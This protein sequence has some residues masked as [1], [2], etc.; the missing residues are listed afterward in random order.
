MTLTSFR[1]RGIEFAAAGPVTVLEL[2]RVN[3]EDTWNIEVEA[4]FYYEIFDHNN[5]TGGISR[6]QFEKL[7]P[8]ILVNAA[9]S[10]MVTD[11]GTENSLVEHVGMLCDTVFQG[12]DEEVKEIISFDEFKVVTHSLTHLLTHSLTHS[13]AQ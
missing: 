7:I 4:R 6:A 13:L 9:D 10:N 2:N 1:A 8:Y 3:S 11:E 12:N 5:N